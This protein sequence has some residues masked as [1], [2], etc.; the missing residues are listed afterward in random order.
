MILKRSS[1]GK[2]MMVAEFDNLEELY[3][4]YMPFVNNGGLFVK[5]DEDYVPGD[6][7]VLMVK[8]PNL[9]QKFPTSGK[10]VWVTPK[11]SVSRVPGVGVQFSAED[12]GRLRLNIETLL[13][14]MLDR[15]TATYTM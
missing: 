15:E 1:R 5:T 2:K 6:R 11:S 14:G 8:L 10:V 12:N 4:C 13:A 3:R 9:K 7:L